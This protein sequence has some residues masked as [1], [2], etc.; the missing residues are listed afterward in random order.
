MYGSEPPRLSV[1]IVG[2]WFAGLTFARRLQLGPRR[3]R[4]WPGVRAACTYSA[5]IFDKARS[6]SGVSIEGE[7]SVPS[8]G[9]VLQR[10]GLGGAAAG[11]GFLKLVKM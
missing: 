9:R 2:G 10:L 4:R 6:L 7:L 3:Q 8:A 1:A 5:V 11:K